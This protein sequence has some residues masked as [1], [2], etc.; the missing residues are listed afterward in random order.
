MTTHRPDRPSDRAKSKGLDEALEESFPASDPI[1]SSPKRAG[2]DDKHA[3][4]AVPPEASDTD[5]TDAKTQANMARFHKVFERRR[6]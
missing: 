3:N 5:T 4:V 1:A 6:R 2:K